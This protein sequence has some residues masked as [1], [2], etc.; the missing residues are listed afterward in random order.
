MYKSPVY[1]ALYETKEVAEKIYKSGKFTIKKVKPLYFNALSNINNEY[2]F[3]PHSVVTLLPYVEA[4]KEKVWE[5]PED[6]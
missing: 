6:W 5:A 1:R 2:T 3:W 4:R